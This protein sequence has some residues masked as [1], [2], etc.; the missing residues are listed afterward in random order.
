VLQPF[1][2]LALPWGIALSYLI[3]G[4]LIDTISLM[5]AAVVVGAGLVV[6]ER[7]RRLARSGRA[8]VPQPAEES[9]PH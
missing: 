8:S 3:F 2:Y 4:H 6:M 1:N 7:E 5:G 9:P